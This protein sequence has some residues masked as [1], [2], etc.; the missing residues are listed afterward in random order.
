[1]LI[2]MQI[3]AIMSMTCIGMMEAACVVVGKQI[4]VND[5]PMA[6]KLA[7]L[8]LF[9]AMSIAS[10]QSISL[11]VFGDHLVGLFT[12]AGEGIDTSLAKSCLIIF[13]F[14]NLVDMVHYSFHGFVRAL[15][16]QANVALIS[17][18]CSYL[19]SIP[20]ALYLAFIADYGI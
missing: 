6:H 2:T 14:S 10:I 13:F 12:D 4:G 1:M 3:A 11:L 17:I 15:G 18:I 16:I 8:T 19:I 5:A 20:M 9:Q 7:K